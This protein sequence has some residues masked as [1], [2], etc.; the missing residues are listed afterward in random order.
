MTAKAVILR[1]NEQKKEAMKYFENNRYITI[2]D[3]SN[4]TNPVK[5]DP[6]TVWVDLNY[7]V[8]AVKNGAAVYLPGG[9]KDVKIRY[10]TGY[11]NVRPEV[12]F[13]VEIASIHVWNNKKACL[14]AVYFSGTHNLVKELINLMSLAANCPESIYYQSPTPD[15]RWLEEWTKTSLRSGQLPTVPYKELFRRNQTVKRRAAYSVTGV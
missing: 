2:H 6:F 12:V 8:Y 13:P 4:S 1:L 15:H 14:H 5:R 9:V 7:P 3:Y 10:S 11:P